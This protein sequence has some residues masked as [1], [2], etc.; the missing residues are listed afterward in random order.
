V[1]PQPTTSAA[2]RI[3]MEIRPYAITSTPDP[4]ISDSGSTFDASSHHSRHPIGSPHFAALP[5]QVACASSFYLYT[6]RLT[7]GLPQGRRTTWRAAR[8][9]QGAAREALGLGLGLM[10]LHL[11]VP[12]KTDGPVIPDQPLRAVMP[13]EFVAAFPA[14]VL[15]APALRYCPSRWPTA[16]AMQSGS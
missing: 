5:H 10:P 2:T 7:P 14:T 8:A 9:I 12:G 1:A 6:S 15:D 16:T 13:G 11:E 4:S 3:E